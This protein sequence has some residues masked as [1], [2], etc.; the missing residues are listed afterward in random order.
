[1][2]RLT[3]AASD[4][5]LTLVTPPSR[6]AVVVAS[7]T[8]AT[9][10]RVEDAGDEIDLVAVVGRQALRVP[11]AIVLAGG[12]PRLPGLEPGAPARV[13]DGG[14]SWDGGRLAVVRWWPAATVAGARRGGATSAASSADAAR[15]LWTLQ[16]LVGEHR[17]PATV[18]EALAAGTSALLSD[19]PA[20]AAAALR[21]VLG[22]GPGLTPAADDA[23]AGLLLTFTSWG[24]TDALRTAAAVGGLLTHELTTRTSAVSAGLLAHAAR[25]RG[26]PEVVR[27]AEL[28]TGGASDPNPDE[29]LARLV[30]LGHSSGRDTALGMLTFARLALG[31]R[32]TSEP[33]PHHPH[34]P[35]A[36]E[37]A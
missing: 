15:H 14:I 13:G 7:G 33:L 20:A 26:T 34:R 28:L 22:L 8:V 5:L 9:Y 12:T 2:G 10:L 30:A 24:G 36:R 16:R 32:P 37:S 35:T 29:A 21:P 11:C 19:D 23:V 17:L 1:M 25:G 4:A 27:A 31:R 18:P 6:A 3:G